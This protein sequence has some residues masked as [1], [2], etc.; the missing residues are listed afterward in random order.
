MASGAD[1]WLPAVQSEFSQFVQGYAAGARRELGARRVVG[2][3]SPLVVDNL[4]AAGHPPER[5]TIFANLQ[6]LNHLIGEN[7]TAERKAKGAGVEFVSSLPALLEQAGEIWLDGQRVVMLCT[8]PN[9][10]ERVV[11]VV[12]DLNASVHKGI[13][14]NSVVSMELIPPRDFQRKGLTRLHKK[15]GALR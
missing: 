10:L 5:A 9:D 7:R 11:K 13:V 4:A 15:Q 6:K 12:V 1:K 14:G 2:V 3:F 8:A